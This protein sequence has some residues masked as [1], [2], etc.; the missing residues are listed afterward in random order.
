MQ[1]CVP[2]FTCQSSEQEVALERIAHLLK[3]FP[4]KFI[5]DKTMW[6]YNNN[7]SINL[8]KVMPPAS[9]KI[10][11]YLREEY[12]KQ[13]AI[14][15]MITLETIHIPTLFACQVPISFAFMK[16]LLSS[17]NTLLETKA[18][19]QFIGRPPSNMVW[20]A[21]V[22]HVNLYK[23]YHKSYYKIVWVLMEIVYSNF[24][25]MISSKIVG[26]GLQYRGSV[27]APQLRRLYHLNCV[28]CVRGRGWCCLYI[29]PYFYH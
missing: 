19:D 3:L 18:F 1:M 13:E 17:L 21:D 26:I 2:S 24:I 29:Y 5:K 16:T 23:W 9:S 7:T 14:L 10:G 28:A 15:S 11:A 22:S 12:D 25:G 6:V 20:A 8:T 4:D 27:P